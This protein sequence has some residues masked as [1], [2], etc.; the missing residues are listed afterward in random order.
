MVPL[1]K[2]D[3][4]SAS[5]LPS[6]VL[7]RVRPTSALNVA[8][9][10]GA[11]A[12]V[13]PN[14]VGSF[15]LLLHSALLSGVAGYVDAAGFV[16]LL[17]VFPAHL[18]GEI[19][20]DAVALTSGQLGA[21]AGRLWIFPVFIGAVV[22]AA[23]VA[24]L[25]RERGFKAA[26][27]LLA[28]VTAALALFSVSDPLA[29]V[30]HEGHLPTLISGSFAVAAMGFQT[31]L[32]REALTSACPTTVMTGNLAHAVIELVD[33]AFS[34]VWRAPV[35]VAMPRSRLPAVASAL[36]AFVS[37]GVLGAWLA[38]TYG[39]L[40]VLLPT[41]VTAVLTVRAWRD[42]RAVTASVAPNIDSLPWFTDDDLWPDSDIP[43]ALSQPYDEPSS[44]TRIKAERVIAPDEPSSSSSSA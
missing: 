9:L 16:L 10:P 25:L 35:R 39:S 43:Q 2:I 11:G 1:R 20:G 44:A 26:T 13:K 34:W 3:T 28:L 7:P 19:V 4:S 32:M 30:F 23:L 14:L 6:E 36:L 5:A 17:G 42:D 40:S 31:A 41:L 24:R 22:V 15:T 29:R 33:H 21:R 27:G 38:R 18:T 8:S 12:G 37:C